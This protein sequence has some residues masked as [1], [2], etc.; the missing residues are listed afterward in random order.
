MVIKLGL[1]CSDM[2]A[3]FLFLRNFALKKDTFYQYK[4]LFIKILQ[5]LNSFWLCLAQFLEFFTKKLLT[6]GLKRINK[7]F[8]FEIP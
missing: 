5:T 1:N 8:G 6:K 4:Y 7:R 3:N 2:L